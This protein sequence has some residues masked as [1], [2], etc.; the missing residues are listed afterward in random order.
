MKLLN[1]IQRLRLPRAKKS[2]S[3]KSVQS[4]CSTLTDNESIASSSSSSC[5]ETAEELAG[6]YLTNLRSRFQEHVGILL[7]QEEQDDEDSLSSLQWANYWI[8]EETEFLSHHDQSLQMRSDIHFQQSYLRWRKERVLN[9][10]WKLC[11]DESNMTIQQIEQ[12]FE[13]FVNREIRLLELHAVKYICC[14]SRT[15]FVS[16]E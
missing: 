7:S 2:S 5:F 3:A 12:A 15:P 16:A 13:T 9:F 14:S 4:S 8:Q 6:D 11:R 1:R 10:L